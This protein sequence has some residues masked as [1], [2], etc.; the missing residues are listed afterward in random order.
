[1]D[2]RASVNS[3]EKLT[4]PRMEAAGHN[5]MTSNAMRIGTIVALM[6]NDARLQKARFGTKIRGSVGPHT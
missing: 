5:S 1:M 2:L 6:G 3:T 4:R